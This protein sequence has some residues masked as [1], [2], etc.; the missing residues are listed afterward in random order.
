MLSGAIGPA[1]DATWVKDA[2]LI[3]YAGI[4]HPQ[5]FFSLMEA[6]GGVLVEQIAF[7]D[8]HDFTDGDAR[9]LLETARANNAMLVTTQKDLARLSGDEGSRAELARASKALPVR[10]Q[11]DPRDRQRLEGLIEAAVKSRK[12]T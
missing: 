11:F 2:R 12:N 5:R 9:R 3:A 10:M 6:L 8:H 1:E 7:P 4:G